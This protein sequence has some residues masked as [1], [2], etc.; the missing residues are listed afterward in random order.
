MKLCITGG[1]GK[2]GRQLQKSFPNNLSPSHADLDIRN[3][4]ATSK[5]VVGKSFNTV[6]HCA[7]LT[8]IR[9]CEEHREETYDVNVNGTRNIIEA[10]ASSEAKGRYFVYLSTACVFPGDSPDKC[11]SEDDI[12]YPKNFYALTKLIGEHFVKGLSNNLKVLVVRTNFIERGEWPYPTAFTDRYA[13]Y[14]Y[15]DQLAKAIKDLVTKK[16]TGLVHVCGNKRMSMYDFARLTD[17]RVKPM[18]IKDYS[19]PPLTM[20]MSLTSRRIPLIQFE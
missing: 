11:Y 4:N 1:S 17:P 15:S 10:L 9:Y 20:N 8:S 19:G 6:I 14:L 12:P 18:T 7:A 2:L 3:G 16:T 13:T 5:Y